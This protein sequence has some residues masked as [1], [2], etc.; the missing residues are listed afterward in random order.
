MKKSSE[1]RAAGRA[2]LAGKW[3]KAALFVGV[4][5]IIA[6]LLGSIYDI[7]L[8]GTY[9]ILGQPVISFLLSTLVFIPMEWSLEVA[10]LNNQ[11]SDKEAFSISRLFVGY[12]D[13]RIFTTLLLTSLYSILWSLLLLVP[14]I[15]KGLSYSMTGYILLDNPEMSNNAAIEESMRMMEGH[16]WQLFKLYLSF[17]GWILLS[18]LTLFIALYWLNPYIYSTMARFYSEIKEEYQAAAPQVQ[19]TDNYVK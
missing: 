4:Y 14:G 2:D 6:M 8:D 9:E 16:K 19:M 13:F 10:F 15:I 3:N 12:I 11:R 18:A 7:L 1:F 17:I 5:F